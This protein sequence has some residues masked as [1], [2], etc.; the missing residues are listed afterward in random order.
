MLRA[1]TAPWGGPLQAFL[2]L[3][4]CLGSRLLTTIRHIED[5]DSLRFAFALQDF[6]VT[7]LQPQFPGYPVFC[8]F[9]KVFY[10][11]TGSYALAFS[12]LGGLG[13]FVLLHYALLLLGCKANEPRGLALLALF[14]FNPMLWLLGNRYMSDLSGA[15]CMMAAFYHTVRREPAG[16]FL[17]GLLA[18]WRLSFLP[19]LFTP[20]ALTWLRSYRKL[21]MA[22]AGAAGVLIWLLPFIAVTGWD[23]LMSTARLQTG[24][25]FYAT[26]GTY[27][28]ESDWFLRLVRPFAYLWTD[29]LG[30]WWPGRH[31]ATMA[32]GIGMLYLSVRV[33]LYFKRQGLKL[34]LTPRL[35]MLLLSCVVYTLWIFF[36]Q[37]VVHQT[38][39]ILPLVPTCLILLAMAWPMRTATAANPQ[40]QPKGVLSHLPALFAMLTLAAYA[41]VGVSL[42][43]QHMQPAAIAQAKDYLQ[44]LTH[45][46]Q[47]LICAPWVQKCL[48]AQGLQFDYRSIESKQDWESLKQIPDS[49]PLLT[50]GDY[51]DSLQRE[52]SKKTT[53]YHNPYVNRIGSRVDVFHYGNASP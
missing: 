7:R 2:A 50:V 22:F 32:V 46:K 19:F 14:F 4:L 48:S 31:L 12:I 5:A 13:L 16:Y 8:F 35:R 36:F 51:S 24:A 11:L 49:L 45:P 34:S 41:F 21:A 18:G 3:A 29:G 23:E 17:A 42:A 28:T 40:V 27:H 38:R 33:G 10:A 52:P 15:A 47:V 43:R 44:P 1:V 20:L 37:N 9:G 30:A 26:G 25:H 39:H 6:D 53:F